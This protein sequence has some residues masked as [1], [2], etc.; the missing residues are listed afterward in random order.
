M[1]IYIRKS[2]KAGPF[3]FNLSKSGIG[4]STG[5]PGFRVG[6]SP[7]GN[8]I[9]LGRN[10]VYYRATVP[11]IENSHDARN[12]PPI[13]SRDQ[14]KSSNIVMEEI[15]SSDIQALRDSSSESLLNEIKEKQ[16]KILIWPTSVIVCSLCFF[17]F[18]SIKFYF[19]VYL[20]ILIA[21]VVGNYFIIN[22]DHIRKSVV[23][24]Y[25]LDDNIAITFQKLNEEFEKILL[26]RR[27]WHVSSSGQITN[28][29]AQKINAGADMLITRKVIA[30][31]CKGPSM[32]KTNIKVPTIPV[33][34]QTLYFFPDRLL[35][36]E[37]NR[38]GAVA[39]QNLKVTR[40]DSN[41]IETEGVLSDSKVVGHTWKY[42]NKKGGP[43][44][45]YKDN[46]E[47]PIVLYSEIRFSSESGL[48]ELI[49]LSRSGCGEEFI[50]A[51]RELGS[52]IVYPN[53]ESE[54]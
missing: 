13:V 37:E 29:Y 38:V 31:S 18:L 22:Y 32:I 7:R 5:I 45:R 54:N 16:D 12:P 21:F 8:Y 3:R 28:P 9:H 34:N 10:G 40:N 39:Y 4:V 17:F 20:L 41:F 14:A 23:L 42:V 33:G 46:R 2:I 49:S 53:Q 19:W 47:L 11:S 27:I 50:N 52:Q 35:V 15:E 48:K 44:A 26:C 36:S 43:D 25:D 51:I 6:I 30:L 1:G 24:F